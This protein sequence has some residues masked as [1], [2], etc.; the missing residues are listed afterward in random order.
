MCC[1]STMAYIDRYDYN[2]ILL[3]R[4]ARK[5]DSD[6]NVLYFIDYSKGITSLGR[7]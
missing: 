5:L 3:Q 6:V 4:A 2:N 1:L 7:R